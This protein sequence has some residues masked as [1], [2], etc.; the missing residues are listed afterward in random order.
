MLNLNLKGILFTIFQ[1]G[2]QSYSG[3]VKDFIFSIIFSLSISCLLAPSLP[4]SFL[5]PAI[6]F[7]GPLPWR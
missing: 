5:S 3:L 4:V 7:S 1:F 2:S 6:F